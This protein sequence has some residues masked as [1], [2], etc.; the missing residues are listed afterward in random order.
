MK[1]RTQLDALG[2]G[3]LARDLPGWA[4]HEVIASALGFG[5]RGIETALSLT[6]GRPYVWAT[7]FENVHSFWTFNEEPVVVDGARHA[8]IETYYH[9]QKPRPFDAQAWDSRRVDVMRAGLQVKFARADLRALLLATQDHPLVAIKPD[10]FWGVDA[11]VGGENMLAR[12]LEEIR[13]EIRL[14]L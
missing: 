6:G 13:H 1:Q 10:R 4:P 5:T 9:A 2:L 8:C 7:E 11:R 12:L 14:T 3:S